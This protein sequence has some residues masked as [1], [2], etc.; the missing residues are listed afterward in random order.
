MYSGVL[1]VKWPLSLMTLKSAGTYG[2]AVN[3]A[4]LLV[5]EIPEMALHLDLG[6]LSLPAASLRHFLCVLRYCS[7]PT[8]SQP[9]CH[10]SLLLR[11]TNILNIVYTFLIL[12]SLFRATMLWPPHQLRKPRV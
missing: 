12:W 3:S 7:F 5:A 11:A 4:T 10:L 1:R 8:T 9:L 2:W 6:D